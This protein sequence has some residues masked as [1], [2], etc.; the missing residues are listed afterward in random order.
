MRSRTCLFLLGLFLS[1]QPFARAQ[2]GAPDEP[3]R[4]VAILLYPGV[5]LLDFAGP[6]EVFS[7]AMS[8][9]GEHFRVYT[10]AETREPLLSQ[11]CLTIVPEFTIADCPPPD[12]FVVP[13]GDVPLSRP[14]LVAWVQKCAREAVAMSVCN[15]ALLFARAGLLD[16]LEATT[17]RSALQSLRS[18][19]PTTRVV[20]ERRFVDNGRVITAAGISAGI[21][22][23]LH[24]VER[25][26]GHES[27]ARTA[28]YMEYRWDPEGAEEYHR[29]VIAAGMPPGPALELVRVALAEGVEAALAWRRSLAAPPSE[30]AMN[31]AGYSFLQGGRPEDA[32]RVLE[33]NTAAFPDSPN[34]WD[35]LA[36]A[37]LALGRDA[38]ALAHT[39]RCL[40]L[41]DA[42]A[43][44][45]AEHGARVRQ[46]AQD[47]L[48]RIQSAETGAGAEEEWMCAPCAGDCHGRAHPAPGFCPGCGMALIPMAEYRRQLSRQAGAADTG[49]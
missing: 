37:C 17:H 36:D 5:E 48:A 32:R 43:D 20:P 14:A 35:S 4:N 24:V 45:E 30:Q 19:S 33:L 11:G 26:L 39:R 15:G 13:G 31:A 16:G 12:L 41:L 7:S 8:P 10:V 23:A 46:A 38:E 3:V 29:T 49:D 18:S 27:A 25:L 44:L 9:A 34:A 22:G 47:K 1:L 42:G 28:Y 40:A 6:L 2:G 21:D